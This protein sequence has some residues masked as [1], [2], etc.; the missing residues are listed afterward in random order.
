LSLIELHA[1][2]LPFVDDGVKSK[3][4]ALELFNSYAEVNFSH[5]VVTPHLYNP[6]VATKTENIRPMFEWAKKECEQLGITLSLGSE[7]YIGSH[8][9]PQVLP[10]C[11]KY[12]LIEV[13]TMTEP[14]YLLPMA[15]DLIKKAHN[16]ILAHVDRYRW[17]DIK[18]NLVKQ[19]RDIGV[20]FQC[21]V[22]GVEKGVADQLL[23]AN[24]IDVIA[25]DNHGDITLP[26]RLAATLE[27]HYTIKERMEMLFQI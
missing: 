7:T 6:L 25:S 22:D 18:A 4:Q 11:G 26:F 21:N 24:M 15:E 20:L 14:L 2:L 12:V 19:L 13:D 5:I 10:F 16:V 3:E 1:H 17:F 8:L 9:K 27:R 23:K